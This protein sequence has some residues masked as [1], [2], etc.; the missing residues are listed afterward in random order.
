MTYNYDK[1]PNLVAISNWM[2]TYTEQYFKQIGYNI[3]CEY[4]HNG[5]DIRKYSFNPDIKR[6]DRLLYVGRFSKFKRPHM[7]IEVAKRIDL[8]IDLIGGTFVDDI[9][10][11][12]EIESMCDDKDIVMYKDA[13]QDFKIRKM[14]EAKCLIFPSK[15]GEP[16]GLVA[17]EAMACGTPVIAARDGAIP[18]TVIDGQ[19]GFICDTEDQ[20]VDAIKNIDKIYPSKCRKH[21]EDN[22]SRIK[23]AKNYEN[24]YRYII[25]GNEW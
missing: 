11:M 14:Q 24:L 12:K 6:T 9:N 5:I 15:M 20:M 18:E 22:F 8:P 1:K 25:S 2:K 4:V 19:T 7:A 10:Y 21:V 3:N 17:Q 23:M 13:S 16:L